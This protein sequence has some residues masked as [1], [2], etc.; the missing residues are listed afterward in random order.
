MALLDEQTRRQS[1]RSALALRNL[2]TSKEPTDTHRFLIDLRNAGKLIRCYTQNI[3][4]LEEKVGLATDLDQDRVDCVQLH[5]SL[6]Q[7]RCTYCSETYHWNGF[8][9]QIEQGYGP[10]CPAC[11]VFSND[12]IATG[13]RQAPIGML[14]PDFTRTGQE[15]IYAERIAELARSRCMS[16]RL[17]YSWNKFESVWGASAC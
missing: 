4:M 10:L 17:P 5:G 12:R 3:D 2:T 6:R 15:H 13:K 9:T 16:R 7:L 11:T 8:E 14:L 1:Q